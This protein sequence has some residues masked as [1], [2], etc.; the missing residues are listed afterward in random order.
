MDERTLRKN[1]KPATSAPKIVNW[2]TK[3]NY[4]RGTKNV[5]RETPS[6]AE[7]QA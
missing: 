6:T 4:E 5:K 7:K 1:L 2:E 3:K